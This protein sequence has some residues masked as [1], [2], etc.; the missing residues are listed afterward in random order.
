MSVPD[1][2]PR[3]PLTGH[4]AG[5]GFVGG[6]RALLDDL[7]ATIL[8]AHGR[9]HVA[10]AF[11]R[12]GD[13]GRA[14][15]FLLAQEITSAAAQVEGTAHRKAE[16]RRGIG[17]DKDA[18]VVRVVLLSAKGLRRLGVE[19]EALP[20][21]K[22]FRAGMTRR[23][24]VLDDPPRLDPKISTVDA[25]VVL[26]AARTDSLRTALDC[27]VQEAEVAGM[28]MHVER[29]RAIGRR[30]HYREQFGFVDGIG[31][32]QFFAPELGDEGWSTGVWWDPFF[33][34]EQV[35][36]ACPGAD[37]YGSYLVFRKLQQDVEGFRRRSAQQQARVVGRHPDG[38]PL[39]RS[40]EGPT[41]DFTFSGDADGA[42][43]PVSAHIRTVNP[44]EASSRR[45]LVAR[46]GIPYEQGEERGLLFMA[47]MSDIR[48]QFEF[49]QTRANEA[50]D[51]LIGSRTG[52]YVDLLGGQYFFAPCIS[53][54]QQ[55]VGPAG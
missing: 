7:Q 2:L 19:E 18:S 8:K 46:R 54:F 32:P 43:C 26:A 12:L 29:G 4:G 22:A 40:A 17:D 49:L 10:L 53:W 51:A 45:H 37:G 1:P 5:A 20:P 34:L 30:G 36:V 11:L 33:P 38:T 39:T 16:R 50:G 25:L 15:P 9:R 24:G 47:F 13:R 28:T 23:R 55:L 41:D 52:D 14:V 6:E 44:R 21:D 27:L 3:S 42:V 48:E 31:D 35:L